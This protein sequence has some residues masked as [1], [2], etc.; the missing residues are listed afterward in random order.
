[1]TTWEQFLEYFLQ[2]IDISGEIQIRIEYVI[3]WSFVP[4]YCF[5]SQDSFFKAGDQV[6]QDTYAFSQ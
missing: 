6:L 1:M 5:L 4:T 3:S 2:G